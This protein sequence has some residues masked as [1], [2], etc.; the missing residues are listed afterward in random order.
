MMAIQMTGMQ[1]IIQ[2]VNQMGQRIN[3][4]VTTKSLQQ[5]GNFMRDKVKENVSVLTGD[6]K[7]S[8]TTSEIENNQIAI[9]P[10]Q[11]G[12]GFYGHIL[13]F[14]R[15]PGVVKT[16]KY[17]GFKYPGMSPRPF[18]GPAFENN[19]EAVERIMANVIK[20]ELKL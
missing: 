7:A 2:Q 5:G 12:D 8:I 13:E 17:K 4:D 18:M 10:D 16:G 9:G 1:Q 11:Q 6:L 15:K 19:R 14:G 20:R 3:R